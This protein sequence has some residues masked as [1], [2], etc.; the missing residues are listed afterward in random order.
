MSVKN[1]AAFVAAAAFVLAHAASCPPATPKATSNGK[2][3]AGGTTTTTTATTTPAPITLTGVGPRSTSNETAQ[4]LLLYGRGFAQ[5]G[6]R[7][8]KLVA[9]AQTIPIVV[10]D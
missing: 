4:P 3:D 8:L 2:R 7:A 1:V 10:E 5:P 6:T 9:F